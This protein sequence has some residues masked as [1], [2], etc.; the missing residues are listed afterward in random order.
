MTITSS[1]KSPAEV[2]IDYLGSKQFDEKLRLMID[3]TIGRVR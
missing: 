1:P 3:R 2:V